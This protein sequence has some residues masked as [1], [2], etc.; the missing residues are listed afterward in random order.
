[1]HFCLCLFSY[2]GAGLLFEGRVFY[3]FL[4]AALY[5]VPLSLSRLRPPNKSP[6]LFFEGK[7]IFVFAVIV[8]GDFDSFPLGEVDF[9]LCFVLL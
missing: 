7:G 1:M 9:S 2:G 4:F 3:S 8:A 6:P 5:N